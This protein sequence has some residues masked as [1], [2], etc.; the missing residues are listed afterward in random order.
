M[1]DL[2]LDQIPAKECLR[3][4]NQHYL[5]NHPFLV[6]LLALQSLEVNIRLHGMFGT[7][8]T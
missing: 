8:Y 7:L 3:E 4:T 6:I 5:V 1:T 2:R